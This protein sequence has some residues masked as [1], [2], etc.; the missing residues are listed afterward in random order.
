MVEWFAQLRAKPL[1]QCLARLERL[2]QFGHE[3][4]RPEADYLR[5]DIY[6]LLASYGGVHYRMLYFFHKQSAVV[7]SHGITKE[8]AVPRARLTLRLYESRSSKPTRSITRS[9]RQGE[10]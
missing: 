6:E 1:Q 8:R 3:L 5:D 2:E 10:A 7:V 9:D 4:R